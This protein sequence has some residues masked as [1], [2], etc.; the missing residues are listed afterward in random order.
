MKNSTILFLIAILSFSLVTAPAVAQTVT[1]KT[2]VTPKLSPS[3]S[4][5][6]T[7][8]AGSKSLPTDNPQNTEII[9]ELKERI[10][11]K[12]AQLKLVKRKG[13]IGK[14]SEINTT[15]I[16]LETIQ[17]TTIIVDVDE[18]TK[19]T[20]PSEKES[21]GISD[22]SKNQHISVIG[23]YNKQSERITARFVDVVTPPMV[24]RG[25]IADVD[26]EAFTITVVI[27]DGKEYVVDVESSTKTTSY[28]K[29]TKGTKAG[30]S[31]L[32]PDMHVIVVGYPDKKDPKR[33]A[34]SRILLFPDIPK[35]PRIKALPD[36]A[37]EIDAETTPSTGS[38]KKITPLR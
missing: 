8:K 9:N 16:T 30:F 24:L 10:A 5:S 38:G 26:K 29:A 23:L 28:D 22:I 18:L 25:A 27:D 14:V 19:F 6:P 11:S 36:P 3:V 12:V 17:G 35:N 2:S 21:F 37:I 15:Q 20:S 4:P 31:K 13:I 34:A 32:T 33:F 7:P 1:P